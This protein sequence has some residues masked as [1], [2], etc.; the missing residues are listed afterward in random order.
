[1]WVIFPSALAIS[2]AIWSLDTSRGAK[3]SH[4]GTWPLKE[5]LKISTPRAQA[6]WAPLRYLIEFK[7]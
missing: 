4:R 3:V 2:Q 6:M 1:M 7:F 5:A